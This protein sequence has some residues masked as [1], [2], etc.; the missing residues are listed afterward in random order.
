MYRKLKKSLLEET[1]AERVKSVPQKRT[2]TETGINIIILHKLV[3]TLPVLLPNK[4]SKQF[5]QTKKRNLDKYYIFCINTTKL[6]KIVTT[7]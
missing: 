7:I 6:P 5:I 3:T 1:I 4:S 2:K